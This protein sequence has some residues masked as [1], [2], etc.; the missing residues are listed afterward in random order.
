MQT[1]RHLSFCHHCRFHSSRC[2]APTQQPWHHAEER[3]VDK[4]FNT[5]T[6]RSATFSVAATRPD[7]NIKAPRL[8][9]GPLHANIWGT[10]NTFEDC[11]GCGMIG[12]SSM[13]EEGRE[14]GTPL[15]GCH[16]RRPKRGSLQSCA[17]SRQHARPPAPPIPC[18]GYFYHSYYHYYQIT[19]PVA[20]TLTLKWYC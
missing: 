6:S 10:S 7:C 20:L 11:S 13:Q 15:Q 5:C 3:R 14:E 12:R 16:G 2:M 17:L 1:A 8:T 9:E 4:F 19:I 18:P